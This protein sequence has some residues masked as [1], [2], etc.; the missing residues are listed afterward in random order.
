MPWRPRRGGIALLFL[1][2]RGYM[3]VGGQRHAS[4]TVSSETAR[5]PFYWRLG[6][7]QGRSGLVR[8]ISPPTRIRS[9]DRPACSASLFRLYYPF[10]HSTS[11]TCIKRNLPGTEK[12]TV[13]CSSATGRPRCDDKHNVRNVKMRLQSVSKQWKFGHTWQYIGHGPLS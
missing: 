3:G 5:Y 11:S 6:G 9:P 2:P 10:P 7:D 8:R 13:T 4:A 12:Y 1:Q